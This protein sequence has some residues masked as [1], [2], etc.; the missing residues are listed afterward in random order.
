MKLEYEISKHNITFNNETI[1]VSEQ[2]STR[3]KV[4]II[5]TAIGES[6]KT[7]N[8]PS[9]A[10]FEAVL[11]VFICLNYSNIKVD[12]IDNKNILDT[13][14][15]FKNS[16]FLSILIN[17]I[18]KTDYEEFIKYADQTFETALVYYNSGASL[19]ETTLKLGMLNAANNVVEE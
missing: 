7:G 3:Q 1:E 13:Y 10:T 12:D 11:G 8:I 2:I 18:D 9:R 16:G 6:V 4:N 19:L 15:I 5:A 14:D 17:E